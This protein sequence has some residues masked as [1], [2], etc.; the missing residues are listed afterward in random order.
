[1]PALLGGAAAAL[2]AAALYAQRRAQEAED[3]HPPIGRF[4]TVDG[5]RL[6]YL[7]RGK[8]EPLVLIHGNGSLIQ[9]FLISGI[10]DE[11]AK[12]YRVI[13]FDRPGF[14]YSSRPRRFW[15]PPAQARV[16]HDAL[17][18]L[19]VERA[20]VL[21]HSWGALVAAALT[22]DFPTFVESLVLESGYYYPTARADVLLVSQPA[23]PII[24]DAMRYTVAPAVS[25]ILLPKV[26]SKIFAPAP[27]PEHF[28]RGFPKELAL[29]PSQLRA[30]SEDVALMIPAAMKL[31]HRYH[32]I[33]APLVIVTGADDRIVDAG[34]HSRRLHRAV[35]GSELLAAPGLGHMLHHLAPD[36]VIEAIDRAAHRAARARAAATP[37]ET[38]EARWP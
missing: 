8:G 38:V 24:G 2:G 7:E 18:R 6:H 22:L 35:P 36:L 29:R 30:A 32:E 28:R 10:V 5:V 4:I 26:F 23:I 33:T 11:L 25:R 31:Q 13:V 17:R 12:R 19:G 3:R 21:G 9:D 1:M 16:L 14:G 15:S 37:G 20:H 27:V 34:R